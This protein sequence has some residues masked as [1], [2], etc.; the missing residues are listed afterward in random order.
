VTG[1]SLRRRQW[2]AAHIAGLDPNTDA[3]EIVR[4]SLARHMPR[5]ATAAVL[6]LVYCL[7]FLRLSGQIEGAAVVDRHG[8]GKIHLFPNRRAQDTVSYFLFWMQAGPQTESGR[9]S[10]N[11]VRRVHEG[12]ARRYA[13]SNE[14]FVHTICFFAVQ[15]DHMLRLIGAPRLT[16]VERTAN[17][18]YWRAVGEQLGVSGLPASWQ[19]AECYLAAYEGSPWWF[20]PTAAANRCA[21]AL[22][23]Q[24]AQRWL[25]VGLRWTARPIILSLLEDHVVTAIGYDRPPRA[26]ALTVRTATRAALWLSRTLLADPAK[27]PSRL[28]LR[29]A[30]DAGCC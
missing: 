27:S 11:E 8:R 25:P 28:R 3:S 15:L 2:V 29:R 18:V 12:Y 23:S 14:T 20:G 17:L 16:D 5:F 4:L 19:E 22:I 30:E 6:N 13:M 10:I 24:F 7:G 26:V 21:Q 9:S 1:G